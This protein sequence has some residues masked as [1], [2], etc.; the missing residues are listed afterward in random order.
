VAASV[1]ARVANP[2]SPP[3]EGVL[4]PEQTLAVRQPSDPQVSPDGRQVAF[5]AT[6]P[7]RGTNRPRAIWILDAASHET[8]RLTWSGGSEWAPAW[9]PDGRTLA[10]LS[11]RGDATQ[12]YLLP[13]AGGDAAPLTEG[14]SGVRSFEWSPDGSSIAFVAAEPRT[15]EEEKQIKDKDDARVVDADDRQSRVWVVDVAT[16]KVRQLTKEPW[17]IRQVVWAPKG[18]ALFATATDRPASD[19]N[20]ERIVRVGLADGSVEVVASPSGPF[21]N[22]TVSPDGSTL[23]WVA[24][25]VDGPTP[26]DLFTQALTSEA[27]HNLTATTLDRPVGG[28]VWQPDGTLTAVVQDG[29]GSQLEAITADGQVRTLVDA[30]VNPSSYSLKG[31]TL[32]FVGETAT[33]A[34]E[35]W[36][37]VKGAT[38]VKATMVNAEWKHPPLVAPRIFTYRSFD[39]TPIEAALLTPTD[40]AAGTKPPLVVLIHGGPTGRWSDRFES[41]GQ[42][43]VARGYVVFYPNIRGSSGYGFDFLTSNRADWGGGDYKDVMAGVDTLVARGL[44]DPDRMGIGGWSYGGYMSEWAITQTQRFKAAVVGAGLSDLASEFGTENG[45][46]YDEWFWGLP[47]EHLDRFVQRSPVTFAKNVRTP[48][49]ILQGTEDTTD[50][51]GQ[52]DQLYRPLKRYGVDVEYVLYP[53]EP[54]GLREERHL[55]DRLNRIVGW[56]G[57][58]LTRG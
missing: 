45:P 58:Y 54:H 43:L 38:P 52:S 49:L 32:A 10:L 55:L 19:E 56:Y 9:S 30:S 16:K 33:V 57:K 44:V 48:T 39:G 18:D 3:Q 6:E 23:G 53:R 31:G 8:R 26:H 40:L 17:A 25:R 46:S 51:Q 34:P 50:P 14:K 5:V 21:S 41:W 7:P 28:V 42:L 22:V 12:I 15:E 13:M 37:S 20:T 36:L 35:V 2:T 4:T 47:Y 1:H 11:D 29:F 24:A 27:P